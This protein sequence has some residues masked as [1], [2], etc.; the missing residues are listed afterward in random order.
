MELPSFLFWGE[1]V[2]YVTLLLVSTLL[3]VFILSLSIP[4]QNKGGGLCLAAIISIKPS[5]IS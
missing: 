4:N 3:K 1:I 2:N 5:H